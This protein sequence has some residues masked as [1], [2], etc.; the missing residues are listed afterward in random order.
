M[1]FPILASIILAGSL[2][3]AGSI[4]Q[5]RLDEFII[6]DIP[7]ASKTGTTTVMFPSEISGLF[8]KSVAVCMV[9]RKFRREG[10]SGW[11]K[12]GMNSGFMT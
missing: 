7:V 10:T 11:T 5:K 3:H 9:C 1:K 2:T 6:Y 8:A 4:V 12:K